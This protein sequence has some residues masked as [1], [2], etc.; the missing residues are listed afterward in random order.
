MEYAPEPP[1]PHRFARVSFWLLLA[2]V[3]L[4]PLPFGSN[5]PWAWS[6]LALSIA[7]L[8]TL[9]AAGA[10]V[11]AKTLQLPWGRYRPPLVLFALFVAW[12]VYQTLGPA[13][14]A[15]WAPGWR[16]MAEA[17]A[18]PV[19][20]AISVTPERS[21]GVLMRIVTYA[22]IFWIAMQAG[23]RTH[24]A[25]AALWSVTLAG[26]AY[27]IYGLAVQLNGSHT[28]LWFA[29]WT[30]Y[31]VVTATFV[32]RNHFAVYAGLAILCT[33]ALIVDQ[34]RRATETSIATRS[35]FVQFLDNLSVRLVVL[36]IAFVI[37][38]TALVLT[39]SRAGTLMTAIAILVLLA[40][41][42]TTPTLATKSVIRFGVVILL[43]GGVFAAASGSLLVERIGNVTE[44]FGDR[45]TIY[46]AT[47]RAI[48]DRPILGFGLGSFAGTFPAYRGADFSPR[49]PAY[50]Y[51][52]NIY[53]ELAFESGIPGAL[54]LI[55]TIAIVVGVCVW[56]A[57]RRRRNGF[58]PAVGVAATALVAGHGLLDFSLQ[59]P[60]IAATYSLILGVAYAQ[61]WR[62]DDPR[63]SAQTERYGRL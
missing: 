58:F 30:Y 32:N 44:D 39:R 17:L 60:A 16:H 8:L 10:L 29:K 41:L 59:I 62:T 47:A 26:L 24:F 18:Q 51:A 57:R 42:A 50:D 5:R 37:L 43:A 15:W 7:G 1:L 25:K 23:R 33:L 12:S 55:G 52:H 20:G 48:A 11:S 45:L 63:E 35:G 9:W 27:A 4:A 46:A 54:L 36:A 28:I 53:L 6:L 34:A 22:G 38:V 40:V 3:A 49:A 61:A 13:P 31:D 2:V 56:G 21:L 14:E 19:A